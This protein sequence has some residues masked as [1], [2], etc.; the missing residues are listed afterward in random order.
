MKRY[1]VNTNTQTFTEKLFALTRSVL[2]GL[3]VAFLIVPYTNMPVYA[4]DDDP[5]KQPGDMDGDNID[6]KLDVCIEDSFDL[7]YHGS[8]LE[9]EGLKRPS[10]SG[11]PNVDNDHAARYIFYHTGVETVVGTASW[12]SLNIK[13]CPNLESYKHKY[14]RLKRSMDYHI[15]LVGILGVAGLAIALGLAAV[16]GGGSVAGGVAWGVVIGAIV[17]ALGAFRMYYKSIADSAAK[18]AYEQL[19]TPQYKFK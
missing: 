4:H 18:D 17:G 6:N 8:C 3:A 15:W 2:L 19:C 12:Q 10:A 13:T 11:E 14:N 16:T 9:S 1:Y 5:R 7:D